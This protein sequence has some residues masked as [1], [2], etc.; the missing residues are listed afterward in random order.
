MYRFCR[1][2]QFAVLD[3]RL[4][5]LYRYAGPALHADGGILFCSTSNLEPTAYLVDTLHLDSV[6]HTTIVGQAL[7]KTLVK[8]GMDFNCVSAFFVLDNVTEGET[9]AV[10]VYA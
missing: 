4:F 2:L 9:L 5:C 3:V 7:I 6:N 10:Y 8:K 1:A